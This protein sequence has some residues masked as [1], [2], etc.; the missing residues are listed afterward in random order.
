[1]SSKGQGKGEKR[2][3][4]KREILTYIYEHENGVKQ[5]DIYEFCR[6]KHQITEHYGILMNHLRPLEKKGYILSERGSDNE[7]YWKPNTDVK[8]IREIWR[9][10]RVIWGGIPSIEDICAFTSTSVMKSFIK[11]DVLPDFKESPVSR[12]ERW[13]K[14]YSR[15]PSKEHL[16][17][18]IE[19]DNT[20]WAKF[21]E[22]ICWAHQVNPCLISHHFDRQRDLILFTTLTL[23]GFFEHYDISSI[24][25][26][27]GMHGVTYV[28]DSITRANPSF[29]TERGRGNRK[30]SQELV[31]LTTVYLSLIANRAR[32]GDAYNH[33]LS[34]EKYRQFERLLESS[35]R[36]LDP[37]AGAEFATGV[38]NISVAIGTLQSFRDSQ[39]KAQD[40]RIFLM[41]V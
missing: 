21:D 19:P 7:T 32:F 38:H 41:S 16:D 27:K 14:I 40:P 36:M 29:A 9:D 4:T 30:V 15:L 10:Y 34:P 28:V 8:K 33:H 25:K 23:A 18:Q 12:M 20:L 37:D 5:S 1:M 17:A 11:H 6:R 35:L 24:W 26:E 2:G 39:E 3:F 31:L 13:R 22:I